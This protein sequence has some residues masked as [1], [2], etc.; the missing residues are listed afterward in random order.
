MADIG[1]EYN[2]GR[3]YGGHFDGKASGGSTFGK[4]GSDTD[5]AN[6]AA[7]ITKYF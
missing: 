2:Y 5:R 6:D 4:N 7:E 3:D 1:Y